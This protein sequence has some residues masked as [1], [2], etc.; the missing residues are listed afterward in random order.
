MTQKIILCTLLPVL[1]TGCGVAA[2]VNARN[3]LE[4]SKAA[5]KECLAQHPQDV[6]AC[7]GLRMSY[8]TDLQTYKAMSSGIQPGSNSTV[9]INSSSP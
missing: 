5:Y 8:E 2:K 9:N 4:Q 7:E 6:R 3:D 1:L